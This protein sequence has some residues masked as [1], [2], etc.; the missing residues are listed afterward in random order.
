MISGAFF[1]TTTCH[2][3]E[4]TPLKSLLTVNFLVFDC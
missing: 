3:F 1:V 4:K 2:H